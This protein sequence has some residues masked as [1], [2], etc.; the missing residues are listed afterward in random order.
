M[1]EQRSIDADYVVVG[2]GAM[3]M[4]FVDEILTHSDADVVM[5]DAH[6]APGGH[7]NDAY[8]FVR[9]HQ[10][11]FF[12]GVSSTRLGSDRIDDVGLNAGLSELASGAEVCAYFD[13][14]MHRRFLPS[15]R[16]RYLPRTRYQNG[17]A[18]VLPSGTDLEVSARRAVVDATYMKVTVPSV[19]PPDYDVEP[20]VVVIPPNDLVHVE[21]PPGGYVVVGAGKTAFDAI[22]WLLDRS[23]DPSSVQWVVPR[24]SWLINRAMTQPGP[25]FRIGEQIALIADAT[26]PADMFSRL[27]SAGQ[28]L[29][30]DPAR[31]PEMYRCATVT[32]AELDQLRRIDQVIRLGRVRRL[33]AERME[34]DGGT[35]DTPDEV[36]Y[37]N[38]TAD[39]LERRPIVPVFDDATITLQTVRACQ[40]VFSAALIGRVET[41]PE[42]DRATKNELATVIPHPDTPHD[43]L[44]GTLAHIHNMG[45]WSQHAELAAWMAGTRLSPGSLADDDEAAGDRGL[46]LETAIRAA[47]NLDGFI[48]ASDSGAAMTV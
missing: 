22:L 13:H 11:S 10:P 17:R 32:E 15:G 8:P 16:V 33:T 20:G 38:C 12:Y 18:T 4:A 25:L 24:D 1:T 47:V 36:V 3:G 37:V 26:S 39:G 21:R 48:A 30:I 34:L 35:V 44:T 31:E 27:E 41:L 6:G 2:A 29:R 23:V 14:V 5:I 46:D 40:Q 42:I 28:L 45:R 9:L 7:W 43:F 19:R